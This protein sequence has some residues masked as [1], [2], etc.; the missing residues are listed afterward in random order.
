MDYI[1]VIP[2]Y[3]REQ[4]F[5]ETTHL[6]IKDI[7]VKKYLLTD[8]DCP[9]KYIKGYEQMTA[10][11]GIKNIRN[12]I[13]NHFNGNRV[14]CID[15]DIKG[16]SK[17]SFGK[18]IPMSSHDLK[19][20][21]DYAWNTMIE[22]KCYLAGINLH[23][24]AFF[25]RDKITTNLTYINGSYTFFDLKNNIQPI[26][27]DVDHF[28]DY[29]TSIEYFLRDG[30][31]L[32]FCNYSIKTKCYNAHGGICGQMLGQSS[33]RYTRKQSAYENGLILEGVYPEFCKMVYSKK[34]RCHNLKLKNIK[35]SVK[36]MVCHQIFLDVGL[37]PLEERQDWLDNIKHNKE[38]NPHIEFKLWTDTEIDALLKEYPQY[39]NMINTFPHAF[40]KVDFCRY[41]I[42]SKYGGMYLDIDVKCKKII[43]NEIMLGI[44]LR[45]G[46]NNNL[47]KLEDKYYKTLLDFCL[48]EYNRIYDNKLYLKW[49]GRH[50][51]NSVGAYM[52]KRFCKKNNII[53]DLN[54][55]DYFIDSHAR[56][57]LQ[58][59]IKGC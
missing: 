21:N 31:V 56:S 11:N 33:G 54:F 10:P 6:L 24:N 42:L 57:W 23:Y 34:H 39:E 58:L 46:V 32:K 1:I 7:P 28:E 44:D 14:L 9:Y 55:N 48:S 40:Y 51:L 15:D 45:N 43:P 26:Y 13:R 20:F 18:F 25:C 29:Q 52:Y 36:K 41:L 47:I 2:S 59:K 53:S 4:L 38:L 12:F 22:E 8:I 5:L 30:R 27:I 17:G 3:D 16:I 35:S 50:L 19:L 37:K 49:K